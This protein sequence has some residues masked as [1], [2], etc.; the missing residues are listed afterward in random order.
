MD[1]FNFEENCYASGD[2]PQ[3]EALSIFKSW[4]LS[5]EILPILMDYGLKSTLILKKFEFKDIDDLFDK[6]PPR[7]FGEKVK[8]KAGLKEWRK[9]MNVPFECDESSKILEL[10]EKISNDLNAVKNSRESSP[11]PQ[12]SCGCIDSGSLIELLKST[13]KGQ[14]ILQYQEEKGF[15]DA[16]HQNT[17]CQC[18]IEKYIGSQKKLTYGEMQR[19]A[20][21]I[22][23]VFPKERP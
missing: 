11:L 8:F 22:C 15:L 13:V 6:L 3:I 9:N 19:W 21:S 14:L 1:N 16:K 23:A 10:L 17:L 4:E 18:I 5:E 12:S 7:F 20:T 2:V